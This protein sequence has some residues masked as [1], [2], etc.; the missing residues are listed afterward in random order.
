MEAFGS[1]TNLGMLVLSLSWVEA[2]G[3]NQW[4]AEQHG[5]RPLRLACELSYSG[6]NV[7]LLQVFGISADKPTSQANWRKKEGISFNLLCDPSKEVR[8]AGFTRR[9]HFLTIPRL[10]RVTAPVYWPASGCACCAAANPR[11]CHNGIP[12]GGLTTTTCWLH[13]LSLSYLPTVTLLVTCLPAGPWQAWLHEG[14]QD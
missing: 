11:P 13:G 2:L 5:R 14:Q 6:G 3:W 7:S 1:T 12:Y 8:Q 9:S 10:L 4:C